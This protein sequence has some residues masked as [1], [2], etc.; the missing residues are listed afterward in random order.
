MQRYTDA[1]HNGYGWDFNGAAN[2]PEL[3]QRLRGSFMVRRLK[4]EVLTELPP[5]R[6][7]V[8]ILPPNGAS[9]AIAAEMEVF[10]RYRQTIDAAEKAAAAARAAGDKDGYRAAIRQ[11]HAAHQIA[12]E[13]MSKVRHDTAVA[14]IPHVIEHL[15]DCLEN[16]DKVIV[17]VHHHDIGHALQDAFPGAAVITGETKPALRDAEARKFQ[18]DPN[19]HLFIGSIQAAGLGITLTA[20]Q[21]VVFAELDW[22]PGNL[23][24]AE[25]RPHRIGQLGSVLVQHLVFDRS[26]DS[27]MALRVIEKQEISETALDRRTDRSRPLCRGYHPRAGIDSIDRHP[28]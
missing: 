21:L 11:L 6:R 10:A 23:S 13:R 22:V 9:E 20:A 12:F 8:I 1:H 3:Q 2:L 5:K 24:Q 7:Q 18:T 17:F 16:E 25:D 14:K 15:N 27:I 19:C 4:S 26:V 28:H